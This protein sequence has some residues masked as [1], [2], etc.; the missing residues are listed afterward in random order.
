[1]EKCFCHLNGY[2]VKDADA[3][4]LLDEQSGKIETIETSISTIETNVD[5]LN[6]NTTTI[7]ETIDLMNEK[8]GNVNLLETS[9]KESLVDSINELINSIAPGVAEITGELNNLST[10][11][12]TNLVAA[13]NEVLTVASS[14]TGGSG[15][16][17][18]GGLTSIFQEYSGVNLRTLDS[19]LYRFTGNSQ[20]V[21]FASYG[22]KSFYFNK[23]D[24]FFWEK[25]KFLIH[26]RQSESELEIRIGVVYLNG[27]NQTGKVITLIPS[28]LLTTNTAQTISATKTFN[29]LPQSSLTPSDEKDLVTKKYIDELV[30]DK[31]ISLAEMHTDGNQTFN[32]A[33]SVYVNVWSTDPE[34]SFSTGK[35]ACD[36]ANNGIK[37]PAGSGEYIEVSGNVCGKGPHTVRLEVVDTQGNFIEHRRTVSYSNDDVYHYS[38]CASHIYKID[39]TIDHWVKL[40]VYPNKISDNI[41]F[42]LNDGFGNADTVMNVKILK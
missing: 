39:S 7:S 13:I 24:V 21:T 22:D 1:M 14:N 28:K 37:I 33:E 23:D 40:S 10:T 8:I 41:P 35:L 16:G 4:R 3:R 11:D 42:K 18:T 34:F 31:I 6:T 12:K 25:G 5:T 29:T 9:T 38:G 27:Q 15:E 30:G 17:T 26:M 19:G 36:H 2:K 32:T 20:S